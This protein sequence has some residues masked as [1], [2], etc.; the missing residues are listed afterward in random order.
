[1]TSYLKVHFMLSWLAF[2][3]ICL[4]IIGKCAALS[5]GFFWFQWMEFKVMGQLIGLTSVGVTTHKN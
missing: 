1:M 3:D 2:V 4:F 5:D